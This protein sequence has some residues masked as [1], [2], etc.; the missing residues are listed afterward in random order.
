MDPISLGL[1][2]AS[3]FAPNL[4]RRL[5]GD[6]AADVA[7]SLLGTAQA[8]TGAATP[9]DALA[10]LEASSEHRHEFSMQA[11]QLEVQLETAY[12]ADVQ[13]A[14]QRDIAFMQAGRNNWRAD[15]LSV[16]IV[17]GVI[18]NAFTLMVVDIPNPDVVVP[19]LNTL[20]G[21][22]IA[23]LVAVVQFEFGSSRGSRD[24]STRLGES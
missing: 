19:M 16:L 13:N 22:L 11:A 4:I 14:R 23:S 20:Q 15:I 10:R 12:L 18:C 1:T 8:V 3:R 21:A 17:A 24:K 2:L 7:A 9:E 6:G 5:A